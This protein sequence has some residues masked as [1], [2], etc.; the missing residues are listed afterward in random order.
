MKDYSFKLG[1]ICLCLT[2][3]FSS[4]SLMGQF[5]I[6]QVNGATGEYSFK[7]A[8]KAYDKWASVAPNLDQKGWKAYGRYMEFNRPRLN[9]DGN[10]ADPSI[11]LNEAVKVQAEKEILSQL[12]TGN[13]WSP[14]GPETRPPSVEAYTSHGMGRINCIAFHPTDPLIYWI[15]V[16]Q[17]GVWKTVDGGVTYLPLTDDL[18]ILR[19]SDIAVNPKNPDNIFISV[20]DYAYIGVALNTDS[21]KRHTHY[22]LGVYRTDNGGASWAPTGLSYKQTDFDGSLIRRVLFHPTQAGTLIA[23]G[24]SGIFKSTDDGATWRKVD[25]HVIWD[26]EQD[27]SNGAVIYAT[28]GTIRSFGGGSATLMKSTDFGETWTQKNTNWPTDLSI[29][30]TEIGLTPQNPNYVYVLAADP[31]GGFYGFYRSTD[32]GETWTARFTMAANSRNILDNQ[33]GWYDLAIL[34]DPKN[35]ERVYVGG[36][37]M[38]ATS[39]GG[40]T[41]TPVS[42][43]VFSADNFSLHADQHQYKYNPIDKKYYA[44]HDGGLTRT[45][46]IIPGTRTDGKWNT[47]WQERSN[48]MIIT[49]FYRIG[50]CEMF[51]GYV[52]GGAQDNSSFYNKNGNWVNFIG[53]DGMD[54]MIN[55]DN[56]EIVYGSSQYGSLSRS[57]N[58]G[59]NF[60]GIRPSAGN[61]KGEWTTPM[62][63]DPNSPNIIF[64]GYGNVYKSLNKG[65]SYTKISNFPVVSGY[66]S[67]AEITSLVM[68]PGNNKTLYAAS[69]IRYDYPT[70]TKL[71][72]TQDGG[73]RWT[74]IIQGIP[75]SLYITSMAV[76]G[77][78]SLDL[79]V[80]YGG[81]LAGQKVYRTKDGGATWI[82]MS[83]DLPNI[84]VNTVVHQEGYGNDVVYIGT[85]AGVYYYTEETAKWTL[86]ANLLPNVVIS[87]LEIHYPTRKLYA[88]TFGRGIWMTNLI[89]G[90]SGTEPTGFVNSK[91]SVYPN[92]TN[93]AVNLYLEGI[94]AG[95]ARI[96][97]ISITGER[98]FEE[99]IPVSNGTLQK[100]LHPNLVSGMYFVRVWAG[101]QN[102]TERFIKQ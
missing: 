31:N 57:D 78:D 15:G 85:D 18:P 83:L 20:C 35:K 22:G 17:G 97:I 48:G 58:G 79:W 40:L 24:V 73:T 66:N 42:G 26:I 34:V 61:E 93:G 88:A 2:L 6:P 69:R 86:Y 4:V 23:G 99:V 5:V 74:N 60:K 98:V 47:V 100:Q 25:T 11:F 29:G 92:P 82:N 28:T 9:P 37:N 91:M 56:P 68:Y 38:N 77:N 62:I 27:F 95:E 19:I 81:F 89:Q 45:D 59:K 64:V 21:R 54:C 76:N 52:V 13:G 7:D 87:E 3:T 67:P 96:E 50:L 49:S 75:D 101:K 32:G 65:D 72:A 80:S 43:W 41:W 70:K 84:P 12:K 14:V 46:T 16:A 63:Q 94:Q 53:G 71:W 90:T 10:P 44:C 55:P 51:P 39:D 8:L 36:L 30:R 102:L 1:I 33:Q